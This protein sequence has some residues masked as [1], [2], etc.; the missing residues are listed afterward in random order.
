MV[1]ASFWYPF[2]WLRVQMKK[3]KKEK[4]NIKDRKLKQKINSDHLLLRFHNTTFDFIF[5][6][7]IF[8]MLGASS[9]N[10][11]NEG[12]YFLHSQ[13]TDGQSLVA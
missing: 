11:G 5:A 1:W 10:F 9:Y 7:V 13:S 8:S 2:Y 3:K 4:R 12:K 6:Q